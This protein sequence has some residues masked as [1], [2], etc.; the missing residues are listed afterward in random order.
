VSV[1]LLVGEL[2]KR[3]ADAL[4]SVLAQDG[5]GEA[6][7]ILVDAGLATHGPLEG[8]EHEAV[9]T[10]QPPPQA[11]FGQ[12]RGLGARA[13]RG[14]I[15]AFL[16]DHVV[17]KP[18][19][20][21]A[22]A[23]AF[24]GPWA[25]VGAEV[26]NAN[27]SV[28][29][30]RVINVINYARWSPPMD[31]GESDMLAGNNI[32]YRRAALL[33]HQDHLDELLLCD[34]VMQWRLAADGG[35]LFAEPSVAIRHLNPTS[36]WTCTQSEFLYHWCF[37]AMRARHFGWSVWQRLRYTVL[38]PAVPWLRFFRALRLARHKHS[39]SVGVTLRGAI[40]VLWLFHA[41]AL[42]QVL[43]LTCGPGG[44][45]RRFTYFELNVPRAAATPA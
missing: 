4:R 17:A 2:R 39:E 1:V 15:V 16:E 30:S 41:A 33:N 3:S 9:R 8:S 22:I 45:D 25:A 21:K 38:S 27:P 42:G 34:T 40:L 29:I 31:R 20:L 7:V 19:W 6:E 37:A 10:V 11:T 24:Q 32:A 44:A 18:G 12:M 14:P 36:F 43:G 5:L 28:G 35:R 23:A 13:A 26:E